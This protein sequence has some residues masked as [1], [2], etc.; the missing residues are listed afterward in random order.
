MPDF[1][2]IGAQ[3]Q[4][5][6]AF[7]IGC[8][9]VAEPMTHLRQMIRKWC[10]GRKGCS[11]ESGAIHKAWFY[12]GTHPEHGGA[13]QKIRDNQIRIATVP[14]D[15]PSEPTAWGLELIHPD[16]SESARRWCAEVFLHRVGSGVIRFSTAV[17]YWMIPNYIG[18]YPDQPTMSV[19]GYVRDILTDTNLACSKGA[20]PV[21]S[22]FEPVTTDN[23]RAVYELLSDRG[24]ELPFVFVGGT[25][26]EG[27]LAAD[28]VLLYRYLLGNANV[29]AFF[30]PA[31]L[32]E[33]NY[34]LGD[35]Y[36]CEM[37]TLRVYQTRFDRDR[38]DNPK[39][40]RFFDRE[41]LESKGQDHA[42]QLIANGL[43]KNGSGFRGDDLRSLD[44]VFAM[45]R[46][47][48]VLK[49]AAEAA[50]ATG[51]AEE[52]AKQQAAA[53]AEK[54]YYLDEG[55]KLEEKLESA[56][57]K[58]NAIESEN[59]ELR[60]QQFDLK[61]RAA[62]SDQLREQLHGL[63]AIQQAL[64]TLATF[65]KS[66]SKVIDAV[67][68]LF[69][70]TII[71]TDEARKSAAAYE[72]QV[73]HWRKPEGC[74]VAWEMLTHLAT[75]GCEAFFDSSI[76]AK[77]EHFHVTSGY[78][79]ALSEG[80]QTKDD[81]KL[82]RL[83]RIHFDGAEHD[84]S[85]HIKFGNSKPKLLRVYFATDVGRSRIIVGHCGD[86]LETAGTKKMS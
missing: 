20:V 80:S 5:K 59:Q 61:S 6:C 77:D 63:T 21:L 14:S 46:K 2:P 40:H 11:D 15:D 55:A 78:K 83:R 76:T 36:R 58:I 71:F 65:P 84:I 9:A 27:E 81:A 23:A 68:S 60:D 44:D 12:L 74:Q 38:L 49:L 3:I 1:K 39:L 43:A 24:R 45:R 35:P 52:A 73:P 51:D 25:E 62:E 26:D 34:Y 37:G 17:S 53:D 64:P 67:E 7:D 57:A 41:W 29:Y 66:L 48:R 8:L 31:A 13:F 85:P 32:D 10:I 28:P 16:S 47:Q 33:M 75:T 56:T 69:P 70:K 18:E 19:P 79:L 54:D 30:D 72:K 82:V 86:H 22:R 4:F 50:A 42:V